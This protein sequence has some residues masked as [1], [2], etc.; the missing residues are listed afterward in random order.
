MLPLAGES[1]SPPPEHQRRKE[2]A[3]QEIGKLDEAIKKDPQNPQLYLLR[4]QAYQCVEESAKA[5]ADLDKAIGLTP[6]L[7]EGYLARAE[8]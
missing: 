5:C 6:E 8:V 1:L 4:G 7:A 2:Q 3:R